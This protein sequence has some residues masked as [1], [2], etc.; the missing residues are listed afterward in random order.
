MKYVLPLLLIAFSGFAADP[1]VVKSKA[2]Q[3]LLKH[4]EF[5]KA[6]ESA[7]ELGKLLEELDKHAPKPI[8]KKEEETVYRMITYN[9]HKVPVYNVKSKTWPEHAVKFYDG[10]NLKKL[11]QSLFHP[12]FLLELGEKPTEVED[13][14]IGGKK[15]YRV[16]PRNFYV[17]GKNGHFYN[18]VLKET[19]GQLL[20]FIDA[21]DAKV[22]ALELYR[23]GK[24]AALD[25]GETYI[26]P[27][28]KKLGY[29]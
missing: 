14:S 9:L 1:P 15:V 6:L 12:A 25:T 26:T 24:G 20:W 3:E 17:G 4:P 19:T 18:E 29:K 11:N 10:W 28:G 5:K 27:H 21:N 13:S 16:T 7:P 23:T 22:V 8:T 2:A